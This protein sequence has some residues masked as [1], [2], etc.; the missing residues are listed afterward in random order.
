MKRDPGNRAALAAVALAV[1]LQGSSCQ[2]PAPAVELLRANGALK[3]ATAA[4]RDQ[5]W[6]EGQSG[7]P[8]RI[9]DVVRRTLPA[10]PPSR[11]EYE[12]DIPP[13]SRLSLACG[14]GED[15]HELP[16][17]LF[18]VKLVKDGRETVLA[19]ETLEP[20]QRPKHRR[21]VPLDIDLAAHTGPAQL[22]LETRGLDTGNNDDPRRAFWGAPVVSSPKKKAPLAIVYLVDTLRADHTTPY[23]YS[24]DTTPELAK[25][26]KDAVVFE[27]AIATASWTKPSVASIFTSQLPG[28]HRAVQLRD[29]LEDRGNVTLAEMLKAKGY[30]TGAAIANSV[31][32]AAGTQFEQ[33]F[34]VYTG[35]HGAGDK[36]S[37]IVEAG[38][39]IDT[40]LTWIDA[41][42]GLPGFLYVHTMDPH[43]PYTPPA[44]FDKKYEP[45]P[46]PD[47]PADDPRTG[48]REPIDRD[49]LIAQYD[50]EIAYGDQ[51]FGRLIRELKARGLYDDALIVFT[52]DHGEEFLDHG[53]WTHGKSVHD[54]LV[55]VPLLVKLPGQRHAGQRVAAQVQT[56]DILPTV[57]EGLGLPGIPPEAA[58]G[59]ALQAVI[60][61]EAPARDA[62]SEISHRGYV[63]YGI[64]T[65]KDKYI[66]RFSPEE[67]EQYFDLAADPKEQ[68][69]RLD[70]EPERSRKLRSN[71]EVA[72]VGSLYRHNLKFVGGGR[73]SLKLRC[74]GWIDGVESVGFGTQE[75]ARLDPA[76][77]TLSLEVMPRVG[78][79]REVIFSVRPMGAPVWVDGTR[80]GRPLSAR[81]V[82]MAEQ[83]IHPSQV[84]FKLPEVESESDRADNMLAAPTI[85]EYGLHVWLTLVPGAT[86]L[87]DFDTKRQEEL[88]ALGYIKCPG[89]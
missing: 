72:M 65:T 16:G 88:C 69:S 51:E 67:K 10:S 84:P 61:D 8:I 71:L 86:K 13:G 9:H 3:K 21:W 1:G 27:A 4:N 73:Y 48:Y 53:M 58:A 25:F 11:L 5:Q 29:P 55:R 66:R 59:R 83:S 77:Q 17:V 43:V 14:I 38:P 70:D 45:H 79:P 64:R 35:I 2:G 89:Q 22:V 23:G 26:A 82:F 31:I 46:S 19:T 60:R 18:V 85:V 78:A 37:K 15:R 52:A 24:R 41:R 30:V 76:T 57:I 56:I 39:V 32:Y 36:T 40:A 7:K 42:A 74:A 6:V 50:G 47:Y 20:A 68:K 81:D 87:P 34:D 33:G 12:L 62:I 80:D 44:P 63:A 54:E 49:R 28:R 75:R